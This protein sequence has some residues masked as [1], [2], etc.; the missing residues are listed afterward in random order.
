[1]A[2]LG[3]LASV[4]MRP[5]MHYKTSKLHLLLKLYE[6]TG[7]NTS[8]QICV[9]SRHA[10]ALEAITICGEV[11]NRGRF[12][13]IVDALNDDHTNLKV[14]IYPEKNISLLPFASCNWCCCCFFS[15][16]M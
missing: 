15:N 7:N 14:N 9:N 12:S 2:G 13:K 5:S 4:S 10:K 8:N 16:L 3:D 6:T 1:M 11:E